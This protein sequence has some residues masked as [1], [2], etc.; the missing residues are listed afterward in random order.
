[1]TPLRQHMLEAMQVRGFATRTQRTY[2]DLIAKLARFY[3]ASPDTLTPEQVEAWLLHYIQRG[4][5][6]STVNQASCA[7]RFFFGTV[8]KRDRAHFP[9]PMAKRPQR[10]PEILS[11]AECAALFN[12]A[13]LPG[14][15]TLLRTVYATG[16]RVSEICNLRVRDID[17]QPDRMC[18]RVRH[19]K[20]ARDR[21]TLLTPTLLDDLRQ[22]YRFYRPHEWLFFN[23]NQAQMD[24]K[25]AQ[26]AFRRAHYRAG[27]TKS[28]GIHTL[29]HCFATHLLEAG[30]DLHSIQKLLGHGQLATT[31]RYLHLMSPQFRPPSCEDPLDLLAALSHY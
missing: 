11:R 19:G 30:V 13:D 24:I 20:G 17:S 15:R 5:S 26:R 18:I 6:Y 23:S 28:G 29:R 4:L 9:V 14:M 31:S 2:I 1:M 21:Y 27:L 12:A 3:Q 25:T 7:C 10:H 8:L 22:Y 16:L